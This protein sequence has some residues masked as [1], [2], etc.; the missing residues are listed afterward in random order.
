MSLAFRRQSHATF[1]SVSPLLFAGMSH[2]ALFRK[3]CYIY[4]TEARYTFLQ[5]LLLGN[6]PRY[7][8]EIN[9]R[10]AYYIANIRL[11]FELKARKED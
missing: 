9:A 1:A 10:S 5:A 6:E 8:T 2:A 11:K 7:R 4:H 3:L